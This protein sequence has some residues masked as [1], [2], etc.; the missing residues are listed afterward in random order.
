M[1]ATAQNNGFIFEKLK[2]VLSENNSLAERLEIANATIT[3]RDRE[4]EVLQQML[5]EANEMRSNF[6]N[7]LQELNTLQQQL[8]E[9]RRLVAL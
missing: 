1:Q 4:I 5:D 8:E 7:K 2:S 6:E 3:S 9:M